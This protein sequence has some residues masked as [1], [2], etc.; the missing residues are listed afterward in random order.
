MPVATL[1]QDWSGFRPPG[2]MFKVVFRTGQIMPP[3]P[4]LPVL[5]PLLPGVRM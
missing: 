5:L 4:L 1:L 3:M 2:E